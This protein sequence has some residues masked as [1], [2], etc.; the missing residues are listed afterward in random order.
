MGGGG[1]GGNPA[2]SG[3]GSSSEDDGDAEWKA[4]IDSIAS[5]G[6]SVPSSNGAAKADSGGSGEVNNGVELEEPHEGKPQGPGLKLYQIKVTLFAPSPSFVVSQIHHVRIL[7][8]GGL[9][10][11]ETCI[12]FARWRN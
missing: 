2:A 5:V 11:R 7:V 9:L 12:P 1:G 4:A 10:I 3:G 8:P 6:F